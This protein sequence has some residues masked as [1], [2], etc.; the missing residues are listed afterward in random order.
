MWAPVIVVSASPTRIVTVSVCALIETSSGVPSDVETTRSSMWR[1]PMSSRNGM[2]RSMPCR[3]TTPK[4]W[5][6]VSWTATSPSAETR[7]TT[8]N[9]RVCSPPGERGLPRRRERA[10]GR[11]I[12]PRGGRL[13]PDG[14][15]VAEE[16][17]DRDDDCGDDDEPAGR[18]AHAQAAR[19]TTSLIVSCRYASAASSQSTTEVV[20]SSGR[21]RP[22][23][24]R[25][26]TRG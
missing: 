23:S 4:S 20:T 11:R 25:A 6:I 12:Q 24:I 9:D 7:V 3:G 19:W 26:S 5:T 15:R 21:S 17:E 16:R 8:L 2:I 14:D 1:T 10:P 22:D 13:E 18:E